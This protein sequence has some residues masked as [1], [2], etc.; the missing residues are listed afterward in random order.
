MISDS[1]LIY[2]AETVLELERSI[3]ENM[4]KIKYLEESLIIPE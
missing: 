4:R 2:N 3:S 1:A